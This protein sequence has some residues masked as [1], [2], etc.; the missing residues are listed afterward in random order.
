MVFICSVMKAYTFPVNLSSMSLI[1]IRQ[2]CLHSHRVKCKTVTFMSYYGLTFNKAFCYLCKFKGIFKWSKNLGRIKPRP[3]PMR[4]VSPP[5]PMAD[6]TPWHSFPLTLDGLEFQPRL[7]SPGQLKVGRQ[8]WS[9]VFCLSNHTVS[10]VG[11]EQGSF[12]KDEEKHTLSDDAN[13]D[14]LQRTRSF[15]LLTWFGLLTSTP[16]LSLA[17]FLWSYVAHSSASSLA[18]TQLQTALQMLQWCSCS[19]WMLVSRTSPTTNCFLLVLL[20]RA[21]C[22]LSGQSLTVVLTWSD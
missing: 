14:W 1:C 17:L 11:H 19:Q 16:W 5:V 13:T 9:Q 3:W 18:H 15:L 7:W 22:G 10:P 6:I 8:L 4:L 2:F 20:G 21:C 12:H